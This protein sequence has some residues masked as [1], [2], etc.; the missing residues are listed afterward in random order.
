MTS[1]T[2]NVERALAAFV[3]AIEPVLAAELQPKLREGMPWTALLANKSGSD[4]RDP[5]LVLRALTETLGPLGR[6]FDDRLGRAGTRTAEELLRLVRDDGPAEQLRSAATA[7]LRRF[8]IESA[9]GDAP[10]GT[11]VAYGSGDALPAEIDL[12]CADVL[13]YAMAHNRLT[14][15]S[16]LGIRNGREAVRGARL[17]VEIATADGTVVAT[18][19]RFVDLAE[20]PSETIVPQLDIRADP[21][22]M[23]GIEEARPATVTAT[24][25]APNGAAV[26]RATKPVLLLAAQQWVARPLPMSLEL[27]A[28]H[29]QP[30]HPALG[31]LIDEAT[32]HLQAETGSADLVGYQQGPERVDQTVAAILRAVRA[33]RIRYSVPPASWSDDGQKV[34]TPEEVLEGRLGTCLDTTV[35]LAAALERVGIRPL[36]FVVEGHAFVGYWREEQS[37]ASPAQTEV[38]PIVNYVDLELIRVLETT[39]LTDESEHELAELQR[40]PREKYLRGDL[41]QVVGVTDVYQ[42][43]RSR[44]LPLPARTVAPDGSVTV[45]EYTP[46]H[47]QAVAFVPEHR[48]AATERTLAPPR[49]ARW[50]NALLDLSLRNR[51]I[52]FTDR[53]RFPLGVPEEAVAEFEDLI[54]TGKAV[55]LI[56][57]DELAAVDR[58]RGIRFGRE[59][60]ADALLEL[61]RSKRQLYTDVSTE[62]YPTRMRALA[63]KA[64]TIVEESGANNLYLAIGS[65]VWQ[66]HDRTLRSPLILVPVTMKPLSRGGAYQLVL[67]EAGASTPNYCLLEKLRADTGVTIPGL[68]NP[69]SDDA[70]IDIT[71]AMRSVR[72]A[73]AGAGLTAHV[74]PTVDLAILQFAKFRL[75]KD[76]DENWEALAANPLVRHLIET[77]AEA[78]ADPAAARADPS[79]DL[80]ELLT[81][82]PVSADSSQ[83]AAVAAASAGR[84]FVLEGPPGTGKSQ[85]ITNLLAKAIA[86][87]KKVLF[88]A[89]KRA[90]LDVVQRRLASVGLEPFTLDLHDKGSKPAVVRQKLKSSLA[91]RTGVDADGMQA[92]SDT[93]DGARRSL[94]R[95]TNRLHE[96]NPAGLSFYAARGAELATADAP[97]ALPVPVEWAGRITAAELTTLRA[98]LRE[99][100]DRADPARPAREHPWGFVERTDAAAAERIDAAARTLD[101]AIEALKPTEELNRV[102]VEARGPEQFQA[103]AALAGA[104]PLTLETLAATRAPFWSQSTEQIEH[105]L[106]RLPAQFG[107]VLAQVGPQVLTVDAKRLHAEAVAAHESGFFGRKGRRRAVAEKFAGVLNTGQTLNLKLLP[108]ITQRFVDLDDAVSALRSQVNTTAGL[109]VAPGWNPLVAAEADELGQ[110]LRWMRWLA[111][112]TAPRGD[113]GESGFRSALSSYA[114]T[115]RPAD[116][117]AAARVAAVGEAVAALIAAS[118][119]PEGWR[120]WLGDRPV[121]EA[122]WSSRAGRDSE[123][124]GS[125]PVAAWI[126]WLLAL[127]PLRAAGL[128]AAADALLPGDVPADDAI[129]AFERGF[130]A[131]ARTERAR[132]TGLESFDAVAHGRAI[133][134]FADASEQLRGELPRAIP[135]ELLGRRRFDPNT[136]GGQV[137]LLRRQLDRQRGGLSV[138]ELMIEFG[139]LITQ[140]TPCVLV[141]PDSVARFF[142]AQGELFDVVVFDEASQ[143]RV[144]DAIGAM[145]RANSVVVV[146]DSKQMPPTSF[147]EPGSGDD[148]DVFDSSELATEDEE[149]ILSECVQSRVESRWLSWHYRSQD[150]SLIAFSNRFYYENQLTSFPSPSHGTIDSG[151]G[152]HGVS[153]RR[154]E[155]TF[156]RTG[157][158][159]TLR[160]NRAEAD[161][162]VDEIIARF[163][164]SA[165]AV[166]SLG[167]VTFNAQQRTLIESLLRDAGDQRIVDALDAV[168]GLFV[169]NLENVQGD[170][171]DAILFSTAFSA[172]EKGVLPLNFG[173]LTRFGGERRLNVAITRARRQ[174][175]LFSSFDPADL[176]ADETSSVGIKHLRAYLELARNGAEATL[177]SLAQTATTDRHREQI[178]EALRSRGFAVRTD[179]GLS[180]F[181]VDLAVALPSAPE[182]PVLAV[183]LDGPAWAARRTVADRDGLPLEVLSKLMHWPAVERVWLPEWLADADAVLARLTEAAENPRPAA[184]ATPVGDAP[185]V[186]DAAAAAEDAPVVEDAPAVV[187]APLRDDLSDAR[188]AREPVAD[189]RAS[190][191][192]NA[193][194]YVSWL[195]HPTGGIEVLDTLS[196]ARSAS[197]VR[198][199]LLEVVNAE[200]PIHVGTLSK[201]VANAFGLSTVSAPRAQSILRLL[202]E[203]LT[204][205]SDGAR[206]V[207]PES[208]DPATWRGYRVPAEGTARAID[209]VS[210]QEIANAMADIVLASGGIGRPELLSATLA[211]FGGKRVTANSAAELRRGLELALVDG[212]LREDG[213]LIRA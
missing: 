30:N 150:E 2:E 186:E 155:G 11:W 36:L 96:P 72:E 87:G 146:G 208:L 131:A 165:D 111:S 88:V 143:V 136:D 19:E 4:P 156:L 125:V 196:S 152:G 97:H 86:D 122:W 98:V 90:A 52:N 103:L 101:A 135:H 20:A 157:P 63:Y 23:L 161:A 147:A 102:L 117:Q 115:E 105:D 181:R 209:M 31:T 175:V 28:A 162:I 193:T 189:A 190:H 153:W 46:A 50:K 138:R 169:K 112:A 159:K 104:V 148:E 76:L 16:Q 94:A 210:P 27:L 132:S 107:D 178:A 45:V 129:R 145:G 65:L 201:H 24:V 43:R 192:P 164:A 188:D 41:A 55:T 93:I 49:V 171:R 205:T 62:S 33:R 69:T 168:D 100:P 203:A 89:E 26:A 38:A 84:T 123:R 118:S 170:E 8:G 80:D 25:T 92:A 202:P 29:V 126:A 109:R 110:Q 34:R 39:M 12:D 160:T 199:V 128:G 56:P 70:G 191:G 212:R 130:A 99:L 163:R 119:S 73:I 180:D 167:V 151:A 133:A 9:S 120:A 108:Q 79:P 53:A 5:E 134:R 183:L 83:L 173:P 40:A 32:L 13:S 113:A 14:V 42:A 177:G 142:P 211:V 35:V 185:V 68:A 59:L 176:R 213:E 149:S 85:T 71:A 144:A 116:P 194:S 124:S 54:N 204:V 187:D 1:N 64:R 7:V 21:A 74:E 182:A 127:Q 158:A 57:S 78:F 172:N 47:S 18:A 206:Y 154:V 51:L 184:P 198:A 10:E 15:I 58:Q 17:S 66:S 166:P 207:W 44:I 67:D 60:G 81:R 22:V 179:V 121:L 197:A 91:Q 75:W 141:S 174:V 48:A 82:L 61:F 139:E 114:V 200:G 3:D 137:G 6:P 77:P 106:A 195:P 37:L 95:Y 140:V